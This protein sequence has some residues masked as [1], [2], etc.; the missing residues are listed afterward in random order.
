MK[1][2]MENLHLTKKQ[3]YY[4]GAVLGICLIYFAF[5]HF[6]GSEAPQK[7][8]PYVRTV[9][10][11]TQTGSNY[12]VYPG[13]VRGRYESNLAFQVTGKI[14]RRQANLGDTVKAGDVLMEIDPRDVNESVN[15][16]R[17]AVSAASAN[18]LLASDNAQRYRT[19]YTQGAVSKA[20]LDQYNTQLEAQQAA[21]NQAKAQ[22]QAAL[23]QLNYTRLTSDHDGVVSSVTGEVGQVAAA[24]TPVITVVQSGE[25]EVHI[26][27]PENKLASIHPGQSAVIDFWALQN[28]TAEGQIREIAPMADPATRTYEVKVSINNMPPQAKL[29]MTAKVSFTGGTSDIVTLPKSAIYQ[30]ENTPQVWIVKDNHVTLVPVEIAG[31]ENNSVKIKNGL[32]KG[33]IV[34]TGGTTKL[35]ANQEVRLEGE[36]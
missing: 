5:T 15:S 34:V 30:T 1:N 22:Y 33:D 36:E 10:V 6:K 4:L 11:G 29:G 18:F 9:T 27:I 26:Y 8:I 14:I 24:G 32:Q 28:V 19:L 16:S 3:W 7:T 31:Y 35:S 12:D 20:T 2:F 25:K 13:E 21:L 23:N 17:A